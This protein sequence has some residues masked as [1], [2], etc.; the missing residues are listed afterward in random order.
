M[1]T[2]FLKAEWRKLAL[3]NYEIDPNVLLNYLPSKTELDLWNN[4]CYISLVGFMFQNTKVMGIPIP[5]HRNFEE[6][7]L[8][9]YVKYKEENRW[10]RG[11]VFIK[12]IVPKHAITLI[13]NTLYKE[14]YETKKM[15]HQWELKNNRINVRYQ[16][17]HYKKWQDITIEAKQERLPIKENSETEFI[18]EHYFGYTKK[19]S[20]ET[21]EYEVTHPRWEYYEVEKY[22]IDVDFESVYGKKFQ[23]LSKEKPKSVMLI[24]GSKI[25]VRH[26][27]II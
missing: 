1:Y 14:H 17:K 5:F 7:N 15:R 24:E 20:T 12:E 16:W 22:T 25:T 19:S 8:R 3:L 26:K 6:V 4:T 13:A 10:K 21:Y 27:R 2:D 23:S 11:T 9:F 18:T